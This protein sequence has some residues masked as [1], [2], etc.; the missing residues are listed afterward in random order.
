MRRIKHRY[1]RGDA[2]SRVAIAAAFYRSRIGMTVPNKRV[3][4]GMTVCKHRHCVVAECA[5]DGVRVARFDRPVGSI[6]KVAVAVDGRTT[7]GCLVIFGAERADRKEIREFDDGIT[8]MVRG[9]GGRGRRAIVS[10][11]TNRTI[12]VF[13]GNMFRMRI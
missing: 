3:G 10:A 11:M 9:W 7:L 8:H 5:A 12:V 2:V 6:G 13:H 1:G 4:P